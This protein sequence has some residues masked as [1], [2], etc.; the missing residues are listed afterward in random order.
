MER[1]GAAGRRPRGRSPGHPVGGACFAAAVSALRIWRPELGEEHALIPADEFHRMPAVHA[2]VVL[3]GALGHDVSVS[4]DDVA[5][6]RRCDWRRP[7]GSGL[8]G[9]RTVD[10][11]LVDV[12]VPALVD[13]GD[14]P[15]EDVPAFR[16]LA[17]RI[18][19]SLV[20]LLD[21]AHQAA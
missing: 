3:A 19:G 12:V 5:Y 4:W 13:A 18:S 10:E 15:A 14:L 21:A 16:R 2:V 7:V 20:E 8:P 1:G 6:C 17:G 9:R 11:H